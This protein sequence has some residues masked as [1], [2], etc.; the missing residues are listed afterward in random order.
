MPPERP[1]DLKRPTD[2]GTSSVADGTESI[3]RFA[4]EGQQLHPGTLLESR[5]RIVRMPDGVEWARRRPR[6]SS[7]KPS[8]RPSFRRST[9]GWRT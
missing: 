6:R 1:S 7:E 8:T 3:E 9:A 5:F 4:A 2:A